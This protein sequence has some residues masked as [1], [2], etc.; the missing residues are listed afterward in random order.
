MAATGSS[1]VTFSIFCC[2]SPV[3]VCPERGLC[4]VILFSRGVSGLS[5]FLPG[6]PRTPLIEETSD[7]GGKRAGF[8]YLHYAYRE[9]K[10]NRI[11]DTYTTVR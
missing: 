1:T 10:L 9:N 6:T 7:G 4:C 3:G 2:D 5:S 8:P 11:L